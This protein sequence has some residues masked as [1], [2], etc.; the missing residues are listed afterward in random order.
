M[1]YQQ[2][3]SINLNISYCKNNIENFNQLLE[4]GYLNLFYFFNFKEKDLL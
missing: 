2:V 3:C 4:Y 1:S